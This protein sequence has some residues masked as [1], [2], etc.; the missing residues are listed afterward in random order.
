MTCLVVGGDE[1]TLTRYAAVAGRG[2]F[3]NTDDFFFWALK[4]EGLPAGLLGRV[5]IRALATSDANPRLVYAAVDNGS[6]GGI[7]RSTNGG[8]TWALVDR[9]LAGPALAVAISPHDANVVYAALRNALYRGGADR[10]LELLEWPDGVVPTV[11]MVDPRD[12][13]ALYMGT[14][15]SGLLYTLDG[16]QMW[17]TSPGDLEGATVHAIAVDTTS[18]AGA[19]YVGTARGLFRLSPDQGE[20]AVSKPDWPSEA[21]YSLASDP[22]Q[23]GWLYAGLDG[24]IYRS[25]DGGARWEAVSSSLGGKTVWVLAFDSIRSDYLYAGTSDGVWRC[26]IP[27]PALLA[28]PAALPAQGVPDTYTPQA[29]PSATET[30]T[31]A[32][33][34]TPISSTPSPSLATDTATMT[35]TPLPTNTAVP[36]TST[37]VPSTKT[38]ASPTATPVPPTSTP[39]PPTDTS[40]PPTATPVPPTATPVPPTA[41]PMPPT[42]TPVP[43]TATSVPPTATPVPPTSTLAP[44]TATSVPPTSTPVPATHTPAP[45]AT[46]PQR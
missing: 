42:A 12:P 20:M 46:L 39:A 38:P 2:V 41:T 3:R 5:D 10:W 25:G 22:Y 37:S 6:N 23:P 33:S 44:P 35:I 16:G 4:S 34:A 8:A 18:A 13:N 28:T 30:A 29:S 43:P 7:Y 32:A 15:S 31:L 11:L 14:Q 19:I 24:G 40:M 36:S 17:R 9:E 21:V 27:A 1:G 45:T 26:A